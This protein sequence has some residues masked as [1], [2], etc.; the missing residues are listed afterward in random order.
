MVWRFR[1]EDDAE[2][3]T[4]VGAM[5]IA[6]FVAGELVLITP[7]DNIATAEGCLQLPEHSRFVGFEKD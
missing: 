1:K 7:A 5:D 2:T 3:G 4:E 6:P